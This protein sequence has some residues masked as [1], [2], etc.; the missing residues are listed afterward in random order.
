MP[1]ATLKVKLPRLPNYLTFEDIHGHI[2]IADI[3]DDQIKAIGESWK[4]AFMAHAEQRRKNRE[5]PCQP[6]SPT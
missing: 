3:P 6:A 1:E 5:K 4:L 2:D